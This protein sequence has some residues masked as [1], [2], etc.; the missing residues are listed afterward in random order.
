MKLLGPELLTQ[1]DPS[2][3]R[4]VLKPTDEVLGSKKFVLLY[5]T[6]SYCAPCKKFTPLFTVCYEDLIEGADKDEV[7]VRRKPGCCHWGSN[8]TTLSLTPASQ[9]HSLLT[10]GHP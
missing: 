8:C 5:F 10:F 3:P 1:S 2:K 9:L 7:E 6:A 4:G